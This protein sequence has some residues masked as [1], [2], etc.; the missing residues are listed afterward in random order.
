MKNENLK[1]E[2]LKDIE[3]LKTKG[4]KLE[5]RND[6]EKLFATSEFTFK[7]NI[8][9]KDIISIIDI[10]NTLVYLIPKDIEEKYLN[11][12]KTY[13]TNLKQGLKK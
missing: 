4:E 13:L 12:Y 2:L 5:Y 7:T 3:Y 6:F 9:L 1:N 11:G 8:A 10:D